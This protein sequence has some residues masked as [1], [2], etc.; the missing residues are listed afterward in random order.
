MINAIKVENRMG[1]LK[2]I[3]ALI[4]EL[5][6]NKRVLL[7]ADDRTYEVA[8][9]QVETLLTA[10]GLNAESCVVFRDGVLLP[11]EKALAEIITGIQPE[12]DLLLAVGAGS[13]NDLVKFA[14]HKRNLPYA[15]IPTAPS[16]DG[17]A[18]SVAAITFNGFKQTFPAAPPVAIWA[19]PDILATAPEEMF[20]A[21]MGDVLGKYTAI[22]DWKLGNLIDGETFSDAIAAD[23]VQAVN[24]VNAIT[25]TMAKTEAAARL[26]DALILSGEAMLKWGNSRPASGSEHHLAHFWEMQFALAGREGHLHGTKVGVA[27]ILTTGL[28]HRIFALDQNEVIERI[29]MRQSETEEAFRA[30]IEEAYGSLSGGVFEEQ[31]NYYLNEE[32]RRE[33]QVRIID[34]WDAMKEWALAYVPAPHKLAAHMHGMGALVEPGEIG[35]AP[36]LLELS[37]ANAK[38]VRRRYTVFRLAED[39]GW[40]YVK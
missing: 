10:S 14:A 16:M 34:Q 25:P 39:I 24:R 12:M 15:V 30:R 1:I 18:S 20:L 38:E 27:T 35:I 32:Q 31:K 5:A 36:D 8:G 7:V 21:G 33:R 9:R 17:Y 19:D 6:P 11:D 37:L 4:G 29:K 2:R 22:A 28:Y 3:P 23:V 13:I 40:E 26:I